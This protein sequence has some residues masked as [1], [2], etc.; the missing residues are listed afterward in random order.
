MLIITMLENGVAWKLWTITRV[1]IK[2]M[3][4]LKISWLPPRGER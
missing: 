2:K 1:S 4:L 3:G